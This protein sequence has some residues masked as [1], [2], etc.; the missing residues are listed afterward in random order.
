MFV[1]SMPLTAI[2]KEQKF[3]SAESL[4][5]ADLEGVKVLD[6]SNLD[7]KRLPKLPE[8]LEVLIM[9]HNPQI[10]VGDGELPN[11]LTKLFACARPG[12][13]PYASPD[14]PVR[15]IPT[16]R[17]APPRKAEPSI[18]PKPPIIPEKEASNQV[19]AEA[20]E[21]KGLDITKWPKNLE[22]CYLCGANIK[23]L[24]RALPSTM[25]EFFVERTNLNELPLLNEGL[26]HL[27]VSGSKLK[28]IPKLPTTLERLYAEDCG[29]TSLPKISHTHLKELYAQNNKLYEVGDLPETIEEIYIDGNELTA[30]PKISDKHNLRELYA[31][32]NKITEKPVLP[33][34]IE[35]V[36]L[37]NNRMPDF[38]YVNKKANFIKI[39]P[40]YYSL[41]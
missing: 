35:E 19:S 12:R 34:Q 27:R 25:R 5:A 9:K 26:L 11:S 14:E 16:P 23:R 37:S 41:N 22:I 28:E 33:K 6:I 39:Q 36:L 7:L 24:P 21:K 29:L 17:P 40:Q 1:E 20:F 3:T 38:E 10:Y 8:G 18:T 15:Y 13:D 32:N 30:L 2:E 31:S 4:F